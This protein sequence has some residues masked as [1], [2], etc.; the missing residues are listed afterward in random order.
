MRNHGFTLIEMLVSVALL[1]VV[2]FYLMGT[3]IVNQKTYMVIDQVTEAQ[4]SMRAIADLLERDLRHAGFLVPQGA[5]VCGV[6]ITTG[7]DTLYLSDPDPLLT[8]NALSGD[9]GAVIT[10]TIGTMTQGSLYV[11][12]GVDDLILDGS[13]FYDTDSNGVAD[14]DFQIG[15][16]V[17]IT[18]TL[19]PL[20]GSMCGTITAI[21]P[22]AGTFAFLLASNGLAAATQPYNYVAVPAH[23]Y[24]V[25]TANTNLLRNGMLLARGVE[26][27]QFAVWLDLNDNNT[28]DPNEYRGN[29]ADPDYLSN[30]VDHAD[31]REMR[32]SLVTRTRSPDVDFSTG[33]TQTTENRVPIAGNDGFRR[34]VHTSRSRLRNVANRS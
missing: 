24:R 17:I 3:F 4:Q 21:N 28:V 30:A 19:N 5:P 10:T 6:D 25:D 29:G 34:R 11:G 15:G 9:L 12:I 32:V 2:I 1:G 31:S 20:R 7:P 22:G 23:E 33:Q 13:A 18:D 16:G 14:S 26:D 8:A 27:M